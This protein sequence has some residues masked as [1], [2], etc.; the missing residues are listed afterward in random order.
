MCIKILRKENPTEKE[1]SQ[2]KRENSKI[3]FEIII[4]KCKQIPLIQRNLN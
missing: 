1:I 2:K 3:N 4:Y